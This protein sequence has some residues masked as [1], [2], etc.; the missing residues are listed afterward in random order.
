MPRDVWKHTTTARTPYYNNI[1]HDV[2]TLLLVIIFII[3]TL[4][5]AYFSSRPS[6]YGEVLH[7]KRHYRWR[8]I[9]ADLVDRDTTANQKLT[10]LVGHFRLVHTN[11]ILLI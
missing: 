6:S 3:I 5:F 4:R 2:T 9:H 7:W 11:I 10:V 8:L 1:M